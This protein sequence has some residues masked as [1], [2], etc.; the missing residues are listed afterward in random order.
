MTGK[1]EP[2]QSD[3]GRLTLLQTIGSVVAS[4]FGVQSSRKRMRDFQHGNA[5]RFI[6]VGLIITALFILTLVLVVKLV[7]RQAGA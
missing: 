3:P 6:A 1:S 7:L 4:F 5:A 2:P